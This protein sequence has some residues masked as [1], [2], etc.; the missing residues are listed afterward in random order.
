MVFL[1]A[2]R[3]CADANKQ[4][5]PAKAV[6]LAA[7]NNSPALGHPVPYTIANV[8]LTWAGPVIVLIT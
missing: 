8:L 6:T 1:W 3:G 5:D 7:R 4:A 2:C